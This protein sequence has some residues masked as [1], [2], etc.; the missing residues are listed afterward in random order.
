MLNKLR[1]ST[2]LYRKDLQPWDLKLS[3][4]LNDFSGKQQDTGTVDVQ[5]HPMPGSSFGKTTTEV[6]SKLIQGS[7]SAALRTTDLKVLREALLIQKLIDE[8]VNPIDVLQTDGLE[9]KQQL[10]KFGSVE[11]SCLRVSP[12]VDSFSV[13]SQAPTFCFQ[14]DM[15]NVLRARLT[16]TENSLR[17][18]VGKFQNINLTLDNTLFYDGRIAISGKAESLHVTSSDN[19]PAVSSGPEVGEPS[20]AVAGGVVAGQKIAGS[21]VVYPP[22]SR[23]A[24]EEGSVVISAVIDKSGHIGRLVPIA[25]PSGLLTDAAMDAIKT[26]VYKPYLLNGQPTE[27]DT[28]ITVNFHLTR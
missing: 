6:Q 26:Y 27:V 16:T 11:L 12:K 28:T 13:A 2:S 9:V 22:M 24:H 5:W 14:P 15:P 3:F 18:R 17:N 7:I 21:N 4:S 8:T 25:S 23:M 19:V 10:R 1:D 20:L